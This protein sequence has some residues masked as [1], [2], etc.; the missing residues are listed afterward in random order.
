MEFTT[1]Y[2]VLWGLVKT[3]LKERCIRLR[4]LSL[5]DKDF[6]GKCSS[7]RWNLVE[8]DQFVA[9]EFFEASLAWFIKFL[10]FYFVAK[11]S[12]R[13]LFVVCVWHLLYVKDTNDC[14]MTSSSWSF[15]STP[16]I[17]WKMN[18]W[19]LVSVENNR[20]LCSSNTW[21]EMKCSEMLPV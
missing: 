21:C 11:T 3:N 16:N 19:I 7:L 18:K 8:I 17:F 2:K 20:F 4:Y 9:V 10:R 14:Q 15:R 1:T 12:L 13:S 6:C 5:V